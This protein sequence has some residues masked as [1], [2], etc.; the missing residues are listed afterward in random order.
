V[1]KVGIDNAKDETAI[2]DAPC[3]PSPDKTV[4]V[5]HRFHVTRGFNRLPNLERKCGLLDQEGWLFVTHSTNDFEGRS[6]N[7]SVS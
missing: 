2:P 1:Q 4:P 5:T 6:I 3:V 7:S